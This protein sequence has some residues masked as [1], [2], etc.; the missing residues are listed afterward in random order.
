VPPNSCRILLKFGLES[1]LKEHLFEPSVFTFRRW[2]DGNI[3]GLTRLVPDFSNTFDAP[4]YVIHRAHLQRALF[5]KAL[6]LGVKVH[7][8]SKVKSYEPEKPS[9]T[10]ENGLRYEADLIVAADGMNSEARKVVL[11]GEDQPPQRTGFAAYRALVDIARIEA[12]PE[13]APLLEIPGQNCWYVASKNPTTFYI[14][15]SSK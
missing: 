14:S 2:E 10:L 4:Y 6:N 13:L 1:Y 12:D 9:L 11:N 8:G 3:V 7:L 15:F 5:L